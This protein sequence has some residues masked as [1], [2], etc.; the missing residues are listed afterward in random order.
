MKKS[1]LFTLLLAVMFMNTMQAQL[2]CPIDSCANFSNYFINNGPV[3]TTNQIAI[4]SGFYYTIDQNLIKGADTTVCYAFVQPATGDWSRLQIFVSY[5][6]CP[7]NAT[8]YTGY[9][10]GVSS[11]SN[12]NWTSSVS[13]NSSGPTFCISGSLTGNP[14]PGAPN[15]FTTL[16]TFQYPN[17][18]KIAPTLLAGNTLSNCSQ[19]V[20]GQTYKH[21]FKI[22]K[23]TTCPGPLVISPIITC[24]NHCV[25]PGKICKPIEYLS[26]VTNS[27]C[28]NNANGAIDLTVC[29]NKKLKYLWN[30]SNTS[31]NRTGLTPGTYTVTITDIEAN[32]CDTTV[33]FV[34]DPEI[35]KGVK[36]ASKT[37]CKGACDTITPQVIGYN[38]PF[39][40]KWN[41][42]YSNTGAH[43]VCPATTTTYTVTVE[44]GITTSTAIATVTIQIPNVVASAD[45][46]ICLND[47]VRLNATG[48]VSYVW[49]P[50]TGLSSTTVSN[51]LS[52]PSVAGTYNYV[53]TGTSAIGCVSSDMVKIT[54]INTIPSADAGP[55]KTICPTLGDTSITLTA[56]GGNIFTWST[57]EHTQ[58][59]VVHPTQTT[60]YTV[61]VE[62]TCG[63]G[64]ATD[65]MK[66]IVQCGVDIPNV[67]TPNGDPDNQY[68]YIK[69]L[70]SYPH[71]RLE[72]F[73][74]W[75][76]KMYISESYD[77][78]W[79]GKNYYQDKGE[80]SDGVYYYILY[81]SD[82]DKTVY[83]GFV[84]VIRG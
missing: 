44:D 22:I 27:T 10:S 43:I 41:D 66:V 6:S 73:D 7:G 46:I 62:N 2:S 52:K 69:G 54:V 33:S 17:C 34:V 15:E 12:G 63:P 81:L 71:S 4:D 36:L 72:I 84:Q 21:C 48:A 74:R 5:P 9:G 29:A 19:L 60:V 83:R 23:S 80:V 20:N 38:P 26:T 77:N 65:E 18:N 50:S 37:I 53:V 3:I 56:S 76:L 55:D 82:K 40:L 14:T 47:S 49:S 28:P 51:P 8:N 58:S 1:Y 78:D 61:M 75:G 13:S 45:N 35:C 70:E 64:T 24:S 68:F 59:I 30:D 42:G 31:K 25:P 39:T 11:Y 79:D 16:G 32:S 57:G 67:I